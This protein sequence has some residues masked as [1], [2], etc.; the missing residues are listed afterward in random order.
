EEVVKLLPTHCAGCGAALQWKRPDQRGWID[1]KAVLPRV[2]GDSTAKHGY[3]SDHK[4]FERQMALC[5][6]EVVP[7][8]MS[9][10]TGLSVEQLAGVVED[11]D[12]DD[13]EDEVVIPDS[14][15]NKLEQ[16]GRDSRFTPSTE[17]FEDE[18]EVDA[19][20]VDDFDETSAG[21]ERRLRQALE[22]VRG[23]IDN[24]DVYETRKLTER[25]SAAV[26][27]AHQEVH[28]ADNKKDWHWQ[29]IDLQHPAVAEAARAQWSRAAE[30]QQERKLKARAQVTCHRC[31]TLFRDGQ[32]VAEKA[33]I[34][35]S[36]TEADIQQ[37]RNVLRDALRS[38]RPNESNEASAKV[39]I[40]VV[41]A[42]DFEGTQ[43]EE[44]P[45]LLEEEKQQGRAHRVILALNKMDL[46]PRRVSWP[47]VQQWA[48]EQCELSGLDVAAVVPM[49]A[50]KQNAVG[51]LLTRLMKE[52]DLRHRDAVVCGAANTG[53][54]S[55]ISA[56]IEKGLLENVRQRLPTA[57]RLPGTTQGVI[58]FPHP[59]WPQ[60]SLVD[61]PGLVQERNL[62][63]HL[64]S[65]ELRDV[66]PKD[67]V[68]PVSYKV[69]PGREVLCLGGFYRIRQVSGD[70]CFLTSW[71][72][73]NVGV[74]LSLQDRLEYT[75]KHGVGRHGH[76]FPPY[77]P[78]RLEEF[79]V[80]PVQHVS[81]LLEHPVSSDGIMQIEGKGWTDV[82][83]EIALPGLGFVGVV[84]A[85]PI[86]LQVESPH[87]RAVHVREPLL[88]EWR[89]HT[90]RY[91][92]NPRTRTR[93]H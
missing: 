21:W 23:P 55:L 14:Q 16:V 18:L 60:R 66:M 41:D 89:A 44:L 84:A 35:V 68:L 61:T 27:E 86:E 69:E 8:L 83:C 20:G 31:M 82:A 54:S 40:V 5:R 12:D 51:R 32:N 13:E 91:I 77:S 52:H 11:D 33:G 71:V 63:S 19:D 9:Q 28:G 25:P 81:G 87:G 2:R 76:I 37:F 78:E 15:W 48:R 70:P 50:K 72:S 57:S 85:G 75:L 79:N 93:R 47:R 46:L 42:F 65:D 39:L 38:Q 4:K 64:R 7:L 3:V 45:Q 90:R 59:V 88:Q 49:S 67:R 22:R 36:P 53:K 30:Q 6:A 10:V 73:R 92:A 62:L 24:R 1:A 56:L 80:S 43:L 17:E 26:V 34:A 58:P 29:D 74:H